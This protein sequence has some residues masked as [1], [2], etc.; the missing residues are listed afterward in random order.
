VLLGHQEGRSRTSHALPR[1]V[2]GRPG[3][4]PGPVCWVL[5]ITVSR[6]PPLGEVELAFAAHPV[7]T[8]PRPAAS[9]P[10]QPTAPTGAQRARTHRW[11]PPTPPATRSNCSVCDCSRPPLACASRDGPP[12]RILA[13]KRRSERVEGGRSPSRIPSSM[14]SRQQATG[15]VMLSRGA[16]WRR[17][18]FPEEG[19]RCNP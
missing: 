18:A 5:P 13:P 1:R 6:R 14:C 16:K 15:N 10:R 2:L 4:G 11:R 8:A 19:V 3:P 17:G 9:R 7:S 12:A